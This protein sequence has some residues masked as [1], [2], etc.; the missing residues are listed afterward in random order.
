MNKRATFI[1]LT[2][3]SVVLFMALAMCACEEKSKPEEKSLSGDEIAWV[4]IPAGGFEMGC[5]PGDLDCVTTDFLETPQHHVEIAAFEMTR[6]EITQY[7]YWKV[8]GEAPAYHPVCGDCPI[9]YMPH[10]YYDAVSFCEAVGGRLPSEAE[11]EY[12]ARAGA[13][14]RYYCGDDKACVDDIAWYR[15]NSDEGNN[16]I[17][18][19]HPVGQKTPNA[20]GLYDM[21]G[22]LMEW[23]A[24]C[25]HDDFTGA[26]DDGA[27][28]MTGDCTRHVFKGG[29]YNDEAEFLRVSN[30]YWDF[31]DMRGIADGFRCAKDVES[32]E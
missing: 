18:R 23:T 3:L 30:R 2:A 27:P 9:E 17:L 25:A 16:N 24:D 12:A 6:T 10:Y 31:E 1:L 32:A 8:T 14:T 29:S 5:S 22:N 4:S 7:Q 21:L 26:P 19:P 15:Q 11:W 20:F 28:W 13:T